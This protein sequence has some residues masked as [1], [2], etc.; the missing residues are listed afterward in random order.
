ML[1]DEYQDTNGCQYALLKL[2]TGTRAI[3]TVVGDDDQSIYAWRGARPDN[4]QQ[5]A[6]DYPALEVVKLEQNYRSRSNILRSANALIAN[7]PHMFDKR[8]WSE[9]GGPARRCASSK[10]RMRW[11]KSTASLA[12]SW[13]TRAAIAAPLV[14]MQ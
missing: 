1:V 12:R 9:R 11:Q 5:L 7:N 6:K 10:S 2:L 14:T 8:L 13:D 4:L 3:S